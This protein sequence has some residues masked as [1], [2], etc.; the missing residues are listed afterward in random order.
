MPPPV[1]VR[2][3]ARPGR[4][5]YAGLLDP[6]PSILVS[7]SGSVSGLSLTATAGN[8]SLASV[9]LAGLLSTLSFTGGA[10][11]PA[12]PPPPSG[13]PL[14]FTLTSATTQTAPFS[15]GFPLRQGDVPAAN[16]I[17]VT[18]AT[19][20]AVIKSTWP[21]GSARHAIISGTASLTAN[22]PLSIGVAAGTA[23]TGTALTT[24]DLQAVIGTVT[25]TAGTFGSATFSGADWLSPQQVWVTGHRM[26]SWLYRKPFG[27]DAHLVAWME[28]RLYFG[29]AV[30]VLPWVE[31]GYLNV[32][33]PGERVETYTFTLGGTQR[34]S[35][36]ISL[37]N[38]QRTPLVSGAALSH[39]LGAEPGLTVKHDAAYLQQT[40]L[41]PS[42]SATVLPGSSLVTGLPSTYTP[43]QQAN[44]PTSMGSGGYSAS[45]GL[46]PQWDALYFTTTADVSAAIQR[47]AY[48]AGRYG[49]H[50]RDES[51]NRPLSFASYPT[52]VV[53]GGSG[54]SGTGTSTTSSYTPTSSGVVPAAYS[55]T[56]SP[57][58]G[59]MAYLLTGRF[60]HLETLQFLCTANFLKNSN[61]NRNNSDGIF[62]S[63]AGA[64]TTRGVAWSIRTLAQAAA[65]TPDADPLAAQFRASMSANVEWHHTR[66]VA[67][68]NNPQGWIQPYSDYTTAV[69]HTTQAGTTST[70]IVF[71][72][73]YVFVTDGYYVGWEIAIG[74]EV[75]TVTAYAGATR[76]ATVS[77]AFTVNVAAQPVEMRS[78]N[79]YVEATWQQDFVTAA[80]GYATALNITMSGTNQTKLAAFFA[81]KAQSVVG[82]F[83]GPGATEYLYRDASQYT[84]PVAPSN[85]AN[86]TSGAGPWFANWGAL[87][88]SLIAV[89]GSLG[90][91][92]E[93]PLRGTSAGAPSDGG[94]YW[95]NLTPAL[96]YAAQHD[97]SGA[98][99]ALARFKAASNYSTF[100]TA[101]NDAPE[102]SVRPVVRLAPSHIANAI[103]GQWTSISANT[104]SSVGFNYTGWPVPTYR[105]ALQNIMSAWSGGTYD[106]VAHKL[107]ISGGGH[108]DYDG[109]EVF[110]FNL[111]TALWARLDNPSPYEEDDYS[112]GPANPFGWNGA[113]P[114]NGAQPIHTYEI[115]SVNPGTG[116]FYRLGR[117]GSASLGRIQEYNPALAT[118]Q[119]P[120]TTKPQ[121]AYKANISWGDPS[122][123]SSAWMADE[124]KFLIGFKG[125]STFVGFRRYDPV[126]DT[127]S[128]EITAV[129]GA[130]SNVDLALAYSPNRRLAV[131]FRNSSSLILLNTANDVM[132]IQAVTGATLPTGPGGG[133]DYDPVR[134][135]FWCYSDFSADRR[136]IYTIN[137][138]TWVATEISPAGASI[139]APGGDYR[140]IYGRFA[141]CADYDVL[142]AVNNITGGVYIYKP[143]GWTM[144]Q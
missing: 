42:Y 29:G 112:G 134:D 36:A 124:Q 128:A 102:W 139:G 125:Q 77:P 107:Y 71:A 109:N 90:P 21:D 40:G 105:Q 72:A 67:Q 31:N 74:G 44:Y 85:Q 116:K 14:P 13:T 32:A 27:S 70:Q 24:A 137:P 47:N 17:A 46:L 73:G 15:V 114:D 61:A 92:E 82:R 20:Q 93:G 9:A 10:S 6:L 58:M 119:T 135:V 84:I 108:G 2:Y 138:N 65:L 25:F 66:Y 101:L 1:N 69:N 45:I 68:A 110:A 53:G 140:G 111:Q 16:G 50:F 103:E 19:T 52:L 12:P 35:Q 115:M 23:S 54:I 51:T 89:Q 75:R 88:D 3:L 7:L 22:V 33:A 63:S 56:H 48:S 122:G 18:G 98:D 127:I 126:A 39:W 64:N 130:F 123:G 96:A 60:Y 81:W 121:W 99:A 106:Y 30:E 118:Q 28:V 59:Y 141:Y 49:I 86:W 5:I 94:G 55:S 120:G 80:F 117:S 104:M 143:V 78:D 95:G 37:L 62:L 142:L 100:A 26:S 144:P 131:M 41:V 83:G 38:H 87:Y 136:L 79:V 34:F 11:S 97:V 4:S 57:S 129:P 132:S 43:L 76:T 133:I 91:R 8:A 113:F